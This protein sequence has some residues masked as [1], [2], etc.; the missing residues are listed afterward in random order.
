MDNTFSWACVLACSHSLRFYL[1]YHNLFVILTRND[2]LITGIAVY[3]NYT[4]TPIKP[5]RSN[6]CIL[7]QHNQ[8]NPCN[9]NIELRQQ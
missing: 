9:F 8:T 4:T 1:N 5:K 3:H 7:C 6:W 2:N